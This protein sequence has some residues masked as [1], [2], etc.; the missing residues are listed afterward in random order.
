MTTF[1]E[2][3]NIVVSSAKPL[4]KDAATLEYALNRALAE[5]IFSDMDMPPFDRS[6]MD[7]YACRREDLYNELEVIETIAAGDIPM[8]STVK[9]QCSKIMTGAKIPEGADCVLMV[10]QTQITGQNKIHFTGKITANN[11]SYTAEDLKK[12]EIVLRKGILLKPQHIAILASIGC[13]N[14]PV[15]KQPRV[16]IISTGNELVEPS[17]VPAPTQI[18]N[19][20]A[21][22]L[23][24]QVVNAHAIPV[25]YGIAKDDHGLTETMINKALSENDVVLITGGVS[26]GDYDFIPEILRKNNIKLL[27]EKLEVKP[28][29]PTVFG[30]NDNKYIFALPGNP[31]ASFVIFEMLVK[32]LI[33][34]LMGN[35]YV[36]SCINVTME[37]G[38]S[39]KNADRLAWVPVRFTENGGVDLVEYH[40]SAHVLSLC[41]ADGLV[42]IPIGVTEIK[43]GERVDVRQI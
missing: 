1:E 37:S 23:I 39:R 19:S 17:E 16:A 2:A 9:N 3:Y 41:S 34:K 24:T 28:G 31:V 7:G 22:Q 6:A 42:T 30:I 20:N 38:Y 36:P 32:P 29:R 21:Y 10:E 4:N 35:T 27:F 18:R 33:H 5:D 40:G 14:I 25:Y 15:S 43:K 11:I 13:C 26:M 8:M 12:G